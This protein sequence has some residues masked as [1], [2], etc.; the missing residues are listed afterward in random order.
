MAAHHPAFDHRARDAHERALGRRA[1]HDGVEHLA[2]ALL[3]QEG[4][5]RLQHL[6]LHPV[7]VVFLQRAVARDVAQRLERST[8]ARRRRRPPSAGA[9]SRGPGSGGSAP[10]S[11][12]SR[13]PPGR[14]DGAT[15]R[16][17]GCAAYSPDPSSLTTASDRSAKP[18]WV[19]GAPRAE[20]AIERH[21]VRRRGQLAALRRGQ[22]HDAVPAP[23]RLQEAPQRR[24]TALGEEA[25]RGAV[26]GDHHVGDEVLGAV[27][28]RR[29]AGP[30]ARRPRTPAAPGIVCTFSAPRRC[31]HW[32]SAQRQRVVQAQLARQR[33]DLRDTRRRVGARHRARRRHAS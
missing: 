29:P 18:S 30:R 22:R 28:S 5:R 11:A 7:R 10:W 21:R 8:A 12:R 14:S 16:A 2:D 32:R 26:G 20:E 27:A 17:G 1:R 25:R 4:G 13:S 3:Q 15:C 19:G 23:R 24:E 31:R 33:F 9:A 6:A